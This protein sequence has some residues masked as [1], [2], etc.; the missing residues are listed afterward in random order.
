LS[1]STNKNIKNI[2]PNE[3]LKD[4]GPNV[5]NQGLNSDVS[6]R[7]YEFIMILLFRISKKN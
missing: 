2:R 5:I 4:I 6:I 7:M 3:F 1:S